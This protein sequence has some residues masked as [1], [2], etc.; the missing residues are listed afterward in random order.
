[1][2][3]F[4]TAL[5]LLM[6]VGEKLLPFIKQHTKKSSF[7][8]LRRKYKTAAGA[9]RFIHNRGIH[10]GRQQGRQE[11]R[12]KIAQRMLKLELDIGVICKATML[13]KKEVIRLRDGAD[14]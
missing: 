1:M 12:T 4:F 11:E 10:K 14:N 5:V 7:G 13:T 2:K 9:S 8:N 6:Q 3:K